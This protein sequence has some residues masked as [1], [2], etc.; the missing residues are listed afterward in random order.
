MAYVNV[1]DWD[2]SN[3]ADWLQGLDLQPAETM[4]YCESFRN[5]QILGS[6]LLHLTVSDLIQLNVEK[7]GH[8]EI[9]LEGLE[10]LKNLHYNLSTENLQFIALKLSCK[11]RSLHNEICLLENQVLPK[12]SPNAGG[13]GGAAGAQRQQKVDTT[14]MSAVA[15]VLDALM[16]MLSWLDKPPFGSP[17]GMANERDQNLYKEFWKVYVN[18]G[19]KLATNAQR[20]TFAEN[21]VQVIKECCLSL[22]SYSD[23]LIQDFEDPM[24]LQPSSLEVVKAKKRPGEEDFG[25]TIDT[26]ASQ[27]HLISEVRFGSLAYQ[28]GRIHPGDEIVQV[29][30]QTVVGW[31]TKKVLEEINNNA[32]EAELDSF[33]EE[34]EMVLTLKKVPKGLQLYIQPFPIP[35]KQQKSKKSMIVTKQVEVTERKLSVSDS[36]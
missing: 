16:T 32:E 13:T 29:N 4:K 21:P 25:I 2:E 30:Y 11:A 18:L 9:I 34:S 14:T 19:I 28:C 27:P 3:V 12:S 20:D 35:V 26:A 33:D 17:Y 5:N 7:L 23:R 22:A 10:K 31:S 1:Q 8:Q 15:D 6:R 36:K 24:I